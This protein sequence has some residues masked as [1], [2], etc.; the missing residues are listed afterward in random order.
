MNTAQF[1]IHKWI[2]SSDSLLTINTSPLSVNGGSQKYEVWTRLDSQ[3]YKLCHN[4]HIL[5]FCLC[6]DSLMGYAPM[7]ITLTLSLKHS[8]QPKLET[9][10]RWRDQPVLTR[11]TVKTECQ[12]YIDCLK[13]SRLILKSTSRLPSKRLQQPAAL[14]HP[15]LIC[16][17]P[18]SLISTVRFSP[19][20]ECLKTYIYI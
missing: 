11:Y 4:T 3:L 1:C 6:E 17:S 7:P 10:W 8:S 16:P 12:S 2:T 13:S 19:K 18:T 9:I 20:K 15:H 14:F 5:G